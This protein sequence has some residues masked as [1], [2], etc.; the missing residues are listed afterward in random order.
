MN[1]IRSSSTD[2]E[3]RLL[4]AAKSLRQTFPVALVRV[5]MTSKDTVFGVALIGVAS[6]PDIFS[7]GGMKPDAVGAAFKSSA[8][9]RK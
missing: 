1:L 2:P 6:G 8:R 9:L 5:W 4:D 3:E 7:S